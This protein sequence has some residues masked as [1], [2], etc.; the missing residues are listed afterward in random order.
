[1][2]QIGRYIQFAPSCR[3]GWTLSL[4]VGAVLLLT[5]AVSSKAAKLTRFL[6]PEDL[7]GRMVLDETG[8]QVPPPTAGD[9]H[10][11][12]TKGS[13]P[14]YLVIPLHGGEHLPDSIPTLTIGSQQ[15]ENP[16][17]PLNFDSLVKTNIDATLATS[18][19]AVADTS[20]QNYL[21]EFLPRREHS[22]LSLDQAVGTANSTVS[23][24]TKL[25]NSNP[26]TKLSQNGMNQLEKFLHISS[27]SSTLTPSLNLE[28]QVLNDDAVLTTVPEPSSWMLFGGLIAGAAFVRR[29]RPPLDVRRR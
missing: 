18:G 14:T 11:D 13:I 4:M 17:G 20:T 24:L 5:G 8:Q 26:L 27:K 19:L 2:T 21:V 1:M 10:P 29:C 23:G 28:A 3:Q 7:T 6:T 22:T 16:V 9:R 25:L 12:R 15:G